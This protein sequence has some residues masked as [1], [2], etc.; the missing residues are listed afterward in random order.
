MDILVG[1]SRRLAD[2]LL[3]HTAAEERHRLAG[4]TM[5]GI[6]KQVV[7]VSHMLVVADK[8]VSAGR[9]G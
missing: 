5:W 8:C 6:P 1:V 3:G 9:S 7:E 4:R 2:D